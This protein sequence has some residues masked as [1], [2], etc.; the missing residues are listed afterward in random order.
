MPWIIMAAFVIT[1]GATI[2]CTWLQKLRSKAKNTNADGAEL[3]RKGSCRR[4]EHEIRVPV[5]LQPYFQHLRTKIDTYTFIRGKIICCSYSEFDV[6][7]CG[8]IRKSNFGQVFFCDNDNGLAVR[9]RCKKC[10]Q[11]IEV[12]NSLTDGYDRCIKEKTYS[13]DYQCQP[14]TCKQAHANFS[15]EVTFEYPP[16]QELCEDGIE[17]YE[18]A[19]TWIRVTLKCNSCNKVFKH[20]ID[21]ETA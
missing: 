17:E 19:F 13:A 14:F 6:L 15:A 9:L 18:N 12:F 16:Q 10:G 7:Y 8:E 11:E 21:Y 20:I 1:A 2:A 5:K 3:N 4:E